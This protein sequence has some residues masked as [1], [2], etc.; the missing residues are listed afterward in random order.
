[1]HVCVYVGG[2]IMG[3]CL[4]PEG[5]AHNLAILLSDMEPRLKWNVQAWHTPAPWPAQPP[6]D[7]VSAEMSPLDLRYEAA[8]SPDPQ[9]TWVQML[10]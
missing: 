6:P 10:I 3:L 9:K 8:P 7:T 2:V 5:R 4:V 1:M